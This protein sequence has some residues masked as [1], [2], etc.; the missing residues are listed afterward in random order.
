L[1]HI[2]L[3]ADPRSNDHVTNGLALC[4][5]HH[6]AYDTALIGVRSDYSIVINPDRVAKLTDL[7]RAHGLENF[8]ARLELP[9]AIT[10]PF[11]HDVRPRPDYLRLGLSAR[12]WP[13]DLIDQGHG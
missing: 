10:L 9:K 13:P 6:A 2:I 4:R 3:V 12:H 1:A 5:L 11:V 8:T 7:D